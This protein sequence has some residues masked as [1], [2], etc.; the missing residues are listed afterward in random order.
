MA[1]ECFYELFSRIKDDS[2]LANLFNQ[3]LHKLDIVRMMSAP[4]TFEKKEEDEYVAKMFY[5]SCLWE[6]Y[7]HGV[8]DK[9]N[10]WKNLLNEYET[11]FGSNWKYYA[12]SKRLESI[13]EYGGDDKDYDT[14]GNIR[15]MN[16]SN[17][18]LECYSILTDLVQ[19]D[20]RDIVQETKAEHLSGLCASL[21][22]QA[23]I[24]ITDVLKNI[25]GQ[26]I[27]MYKEDEDGNMV[28]MTF[29]DRALSKASDESRADDLST[30]VLFVCHS[31][32]LIIEKIRALDNF[33]D[34]KAE[35]ISIGKDISC[36]LEGNFKDMDILHKLFNSRN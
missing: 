5:E 16:L 13:K 11:E 8:I 32:Q 22:T 29:A 2:R 28:K 15:T 20:W 3:V 31:I 23:K 34:N 12:S 1:K 30:M 4:S 27:P 33:K 26:E 17:E 25:S 36:L 9:L 24:S 18:D 14:E 21:Q 35:L 6:M 19:D 10:F 7:L